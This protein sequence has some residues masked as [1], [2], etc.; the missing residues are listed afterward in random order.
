MHVEEQPREVE[1]ARAAYGGSPMAV[2]LD[3]LAED[4]SGMTAVHCTHTADADMDRFLVD[5][6]IACLCPL[7]EGNLGDGLPRLARAHRAGSRLALGSDSNLRVSMLEEM[8]WLEYGQ[9]LRG[10]LRGA[11]PDWTGRVAT[12]LLE[13]ATT[14]GTRSLGLP[15]GRIARGQW[16]DLV[17]VDLRAA[18]L[19]E[20]PRERLLEALVFGAGNEVIL[21]TWVGGR[22]RA[23]SRSG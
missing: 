5:G 6:G 23:T 21:G 15:S 8:R 4:A 1:E 22:W 13:A 17:A 9:R 10:E 20:V 14:G 7:T 2:I 11:L 19:A 16:A 12:A 3:A 18:A